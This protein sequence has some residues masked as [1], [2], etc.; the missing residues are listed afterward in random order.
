[1]VG[2]WWEGREGLTCGGVLRRRGRE[3]AGVAAE[4][5][6]RWKSGQ[7]L[8]R[9][10]SSSSSHRDESLRHLV[11]SNHCIHVQPRPNPMPAH[12]CMDC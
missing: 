1:M 2:G 10:L 7:T 5:L 12:V 3:V 4:V 11:D 6:L 8:R 9:L